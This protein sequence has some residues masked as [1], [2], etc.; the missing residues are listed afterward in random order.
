[1]NFSRY[2]NELSLYSFV[3][4]FHIS[5]RF[6]LQL[7]RCVLCDVILT[8]KDSDDWK[9]V[10]KHSLR[11]T[12]QVGFEPTTSGYGILRHTVLQYGCQGSISNGEIEFAGPENVGLDTNIMI[13]RSLEADIWQ[14]VSSKSAILFSPFWRLS[15]NLIEVDFFHVI[16]AIY[17]RVKQLRYILLQLV[18][19]QIT[20]W[21]D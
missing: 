10:H 7:H 15:T 2:E 20:N 21:L 6:L 1:M 12:S 5:E 16:Q 17:L 19:G 9:T 11:K 14:I 4:R 13:L 18:L 3:C 8:V